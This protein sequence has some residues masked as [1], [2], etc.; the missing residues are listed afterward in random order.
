[1]EDIAKQCDEYHSKLISLQREHE[2]L[3]EE[4]KALKEEVISFFFLIISYFK[5]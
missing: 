4:N 5:N 1:M 2:H 3:Q